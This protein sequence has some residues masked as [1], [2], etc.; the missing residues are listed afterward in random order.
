M[1]SPREAVDWLSWGP[2]AFARAG[3]EGRPVLLSISASWCHGC[4]VMD[5]VSYRDPRVA[6]LVA[7]SFVP[8][9]VDADRRPD[10]NDRYN[11][12][13]W[14][15]TALLT[16]SGEMLAGTTYLP[17][18]GLLAML[19][20]VSRA[21]A[22]D[23]AALDDRAAAMAARRR[24][25]PATLPRAADPDLS[26]PDWLAEQVVHA[27]DREHGGFGAE[28]KFLHVAALAAAV[29]HH[30]RS[31]SRALGEAVLRT[32]DALAAS[33]IRDAVDGGFFRY[34]ASREW[35]RPHTEKMLEDQAGMARLFLDASRVFDRPDYEA[36]ARDTIAFVHRTL[37]DP[38]AGR[39]FPS[40][41]ADEAYYQLSSAALRRTL[42]P[43]SVDR[44]LVTDWTAQA[45]AAWIAAG[46]VLG[47]ATLSELGGRA[48]DAAIVASYEPGRGLAHTVDAEAGVR[49][50]LTDQAHASLA[51]LDLHEATANPTWSMLAEE[52]MRSAIRTL[53]DPREGGFFDRPPGG[54]DAIGLLAEPLK[55]LPANCAAATALARLARL[56][57]DTELQRHAL[58]TLASQ[59]ATYRAMGLFGAP[60]ALAVMAIFE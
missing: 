32:L 9:R 39:F 8:V 56:T 15:T 25:R 21:Y 45:S 19:D 43:P 16:P 38:A 23:R 34:A 30:R 50:L 22:Q 55:P 57:G 48:L 37:A 1:S 5:T 42:P 18:D 49:G 51:L 11:L 17:A 12:D 58:A 4:A 2:E 40:Q 53:W 28:G 60:Y 29:A 41:A 47:D 6:D 36:V 10:I 33:G 52:L 26:A 44:T 54:P 24:S 7:A 14:P 46:G 31:P 59:T 3:A 35:T 20:E 27:L 13:G